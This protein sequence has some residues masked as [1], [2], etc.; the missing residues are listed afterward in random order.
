[1]NQPCQTLHLKLKRCQL[2]AAAKSHHAAH[3]LHK[4]EAL[5]CL[6][7]MFT[8]LACVTGLPIDDEAPIAQMIGLDAAGLKEACEGDSQEESL[9][10]VLNM[11]SHAFNLLVLAEH[12]ASEYAK[13]TQGLLDLQGPAQSG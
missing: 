12:H 5:H 6:M 2:K 7:G 10:I 3:E 9:S 1:M 11:A 8:R 13:A 4:D